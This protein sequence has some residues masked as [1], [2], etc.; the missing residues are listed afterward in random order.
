MLRPMGDFLVGVAFGVLTGLLLGPVVRAA[1]ARREYRQ[2][3]REATLTEELLDRMGT[4]GGRS[5]QGDGTS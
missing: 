3:Y 5:T 1:I 2:A 4:P